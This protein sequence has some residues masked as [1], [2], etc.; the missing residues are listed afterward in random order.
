MDV[1]AEYLVEKKP[2]V[3]D[4]ALKICVITAAVSLSVIILLTAF[5]LL[6]LPFAIIIAGVV[7]LAAYILRGINV[8]YEYIL[9][10]KELD[11]DKIIGKRRRKRLISL[12]LLTAEEFESYSEGFYEGADGDL[13]RRTDVTVSAHDYTFRNLWYL[14][15]RH[16]VYGR[17]FL[18][19]SPDGEFIV[20][21][22]G[23]LPPKV[24]NPKI[25]KAENSFRKIE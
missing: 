19:F 10:N 17:V 5:L 4:T 12:D 1:F 16:A 6:Y 20:T 9:T 13:N 2:D 24:R 23:A 15:A 21:L 7:W 11:I 8:E 3:R 25:A 18:L 14:V 22:N